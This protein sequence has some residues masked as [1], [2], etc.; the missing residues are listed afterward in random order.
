[1]GEAGL[2]VSGIS[3]RGYQS[4]DISQRISVRGYQ[5][6]DISQRIT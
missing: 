5:S 1:M 6:E 3:V 2:A 4:E